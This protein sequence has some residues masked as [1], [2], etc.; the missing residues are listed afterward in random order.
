M[1]KPLEEI[2][3]G[4]DR[5]LFWL[6]GNGVWHNADG[7]I[8][9]KRIARYLHRCIRRDAKGY[10]VG[11]IREKVRE[12]VY[13]RYAD[14][15]LFALDLLREDPIALLLNTGRH[16]RLRPKNLTIEHDAL[17]MHVGAERIKFT[18]RCLIKIAELLEEDA[19]GDYIRIKDRR[20]RIR[21]RS[22]APAEKTVHDHGPPVAARRKN[23]CTKC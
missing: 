16:V 21:Q 9:H 2:V 15:A 20:Y 13:F 11:Q 3:I 19:A 5:A 18:P 8:A 22:V 7:P 12:K 6:D 23:P 1:S 14:T 17:Y 10:Y 4:P